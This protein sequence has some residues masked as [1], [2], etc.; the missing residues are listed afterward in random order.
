M[1]SVSEKKSATKIVFLTVFIDLVGFG[2]VIPLL[3][4]IAIE[5]KAT[6]LEVGLL[7]SVY[8]LF[9]FIFS[10]I[11]G[12]LSDR[13]GRRPI[14]LISLLGSSL[15]YLGFAFSQSLLVFFLSRILAGIFGANI[16]TAMAYMADITG[17]E[18]RSKGMGMIGAAF[19]LGF[20]FGPFLGGVFGDLGM[21]LGSTPPFG[22]NFSALIAAI[23][24]FAN[25]LWAWKTLKESLDISQKSL[26]KKS[27]RFELFWRHL[28]KP[29][30]GPLIYIFF[31]L[32]LAM[33]H[34]EAT[35]F[36]F[37]KDKFNWDLQLASFGFAY[38]G[39]VIAFTQGFLVRKFLPIYGEKRLLL[40][41]I[42]LFTFSMGA[43]TFTHSVW[44][45]AVVMTFLAIGNGLA[46]PSIS[47]SISLLTSKNEQGTVMGVN[48][49]VASLGRIIGP[50]SGGW[51]YGK[52]GIT[53]PYYAGSILGFIAI[54]IVFKIFSKLPESAKR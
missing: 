28:N 19:G 9:Q 7:M 20:V 39:V 21:K 53:T 30:I 11:W 45:L 14:L 32:G 17:A 38:V 25:F 16:S 3:P 1:L 33:A 41:G 2:I 6:P 37:V 24:C 50:A 18:N 43:I 46:H 27:S 5:Y 51:L 48:Q 22:I 44:L 26:V 34:M 36:I 49:G 15:S 31:L 23:I 13:I 42:L 29:I 8:S 40:I 10:P 47:G 35:L 12:K 52:L 54:L 4:Y